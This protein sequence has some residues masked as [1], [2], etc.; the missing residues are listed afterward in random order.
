M[1][2]LFRCAGIVVLMAIVMA[3]VPAGAGAQEQMGQL[4]YGF[5]FNASVGAVIPS[6]DEFGNSVYIRGGAGYEISEN[7]AIDVGIGRFASDVDNNLDTPPSNTIADGEMKVLPV[8]ATLQLRYPVPQLYGT[9]YGLAGLGYYFIDYSWSS[10]AESY[11]DEVAALY[12]APRQEV[13]DS[14]GFHLGGGFEYPLTA[15][16][17]LDVE[18]QYLFLNPA[19]EGMWRDLVTGEPYSF[20]NDIDLNSWILSFGIK[21]VF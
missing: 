3:I 8:T 11:F 6:T 1:A 10:Q 18:G 14:F 17:S 7:V 15:Q 16:L 13:S 21:F 2:M 12:G 20:D 5:D 19:A 4:Y 9:V